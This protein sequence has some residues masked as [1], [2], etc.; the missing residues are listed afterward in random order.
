[1]LC[2]LPISLADVAL[3]GVE[4]LNPETLRDARLSTFMEILRK[5][6]GWY[7]DLERQF[8]ANTDHVFDQPTLTSERRLHLQLVAA[9]G[10]Y[11]ILLD[12]MRRLGTTPEAVRSA[13]IKE[14]IQFMKKEESLRGARFATWVDPTLVYAYELARNQYGGVI[15]EK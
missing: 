15:R 7:V 6:E 14:F 11:E 10:A 5:R 12:H 2:R 4:R 8:R 9:L 13:R 3:I 1:M